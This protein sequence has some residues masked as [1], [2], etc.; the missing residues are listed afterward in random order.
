MWGKNMYDNVKHQIQD[1]DF[2]REGKVRDWNWNGYKRVFHCIYIFSY[3]ISEA[4]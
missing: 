1:I 3:K 2:L 4:E